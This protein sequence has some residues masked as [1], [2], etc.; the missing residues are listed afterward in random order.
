M[1]YGAALRI[2]ENMMA[3]YSLNG[4]PLTLIMICPLPL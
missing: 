4:S 1:S 2:E 3:N